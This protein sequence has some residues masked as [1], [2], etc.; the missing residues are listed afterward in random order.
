MVLTPSVDGA[1]KREVL[2]V[3]SY[4]L[5]L[6]VGGLSTASMV[7]LLGGLAQPL[8][9]S[10]G[11]GILLLGATMTLLRDFSAFSFSLPQSH[12]QVGE[13]IF[14]RRTQGAFLFGLQLGVGVLTRISSTTPYLLCVAV[15]LTS[16][17]YVVAIAAG[18]GFGI[19]R[20]FVP[21][22]RL[23]SRRGE[24]WDRGMDDKISL[25]V[26]SAAILAAISILMITQSRVAK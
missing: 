18:T 22:L 1:R 10:V 2:E 24:A 17:P 14:R 3:S 26:R 11:A 5:G 15:L 23:M 13:S 25:I 19:G 8:P 21:W 16:P 4:S 6:G 20:A 7:W 12:Y 9:A